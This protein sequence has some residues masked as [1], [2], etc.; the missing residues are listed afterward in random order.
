LQ[1]FEHDIDIAYQLLVASVETVAGEALSAYVPTDK[2]MISAKKSV[3][4]LAKKYGLSAEQAQKLAIEACKG[5][6][7]ASRKFTKF[8][9]DNAT[10]EIWKEDDLFKLPTTFLPQKEDFET[11]LNTIYSARGKL[12]HSGHSF[13]ASSAIG[14]GPTISSRVFM[15]FDWSSKAFPPIVW[16]QHVVSNAL[17]SFVERALQSIVE[18]ETPNTNPDAA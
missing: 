13:P 10:D 1:Q 18:N 17:N 2:E 6:P 16:F 3:A 15:D 12:T 8:L 9:I 7:W 5:I 11:A 4:S 14:I